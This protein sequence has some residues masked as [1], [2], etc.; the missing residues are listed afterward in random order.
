MAAVAVPLPTLRWA[1]VAT[2]LRCDYESVWIA[3]QVLEASGEVYVNEPQ[4]V[5]AIAPF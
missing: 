4:T 3:L 1:I 5:V 2:L